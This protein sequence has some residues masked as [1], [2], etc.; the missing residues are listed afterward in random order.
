MQVY[1][2]GS[3]CSLSCLSPNR[4]DV[5]QTRALCACVEIRALEPAVNSVPR[6]ELVFRKQAS[7]VTVVALE[8]HTGLLGGVAL[9]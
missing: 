8:V 4:T 6:D 2:V 5:R 7:Q 3:L 1:I 9:E